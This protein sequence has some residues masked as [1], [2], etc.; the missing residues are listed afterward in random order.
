MQKFLEDLDAV[1]VDASE[2]ASEEVMLTA[3]ICVLPAMV[4]ERMDAFIC[5]FDPTKTHYVPT[6][7]FMGNVLTS[8]AFASGLRPTPL[9]SV[10]LTTLSH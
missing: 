1:L 7:T 3:A 6:V 10:T 5:K 8:D 2:D 4:K 9:V